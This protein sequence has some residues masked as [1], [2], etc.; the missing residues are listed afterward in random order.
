MNDFTGQSLDIGHITKILLKKIF[1]FFGSQT[2]QPE[3]HKHRILFVLF[4]CRIGKYCRKLPVYLP[5]DLRQP[6][7]KSFKGIKA[8]GQ[9]KPG[10]VQTVPGDGLRLFIP[11]F[12]KQVFSPAEKNIA[13]TQHLTGILINTATVPE[14]NQH[15]EQRSFLQIPDAPAPHQLKNLSHKLHLPDAAFAQLEVPEKMPPTHLGLDKGFHLPKR[16][17]CSE[18]QISPVDKG[19]KHVHKLFACR[20]LISQHPALDHGIAFPGSAMSEIIVFQGCKGAYQGAAVP[21]RPETHVNPVDKAVPGLLLQNLNKLLSQTGEK[22]LVVHRLPAPHGFASF[23]VAENQINVRRKVELVPAQ[24]AHADNQ[25]FL[26]S[27]GCGRNGDAADSGIKPVEVIQNFHHHRFGQ[28][29]RMHKAFVKGCLAQ[30]L[31]YGN[32]RHFVVS[33]FTHRLFKEV[34]ILNIPDQHPDLG[35]VGFIAVRP[36]VFP[37]FQHSDKTAAPFNGI[38]GHVIGISKDLPDKLPMFFKN[39]KLR[40]LNPFKKSF[41]IFFRLSGHLVC[42]HHETVLV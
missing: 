4:F 41:Q 32:N 16:L 14:G 5:H 29:R 40:I 42:N 26:G 2:Y 3:I 13:L 22:H 28:K 8:H 10:L 24:L 17:D 11:N 33:E 30:N 9:V 34:Q 23:R 35:S 38:P 19:A 7:G 27:S 25:H 1:N 31:P 37:G 6:V 15:F 12:L 36:F 39:F 20:S 21:E 18:V